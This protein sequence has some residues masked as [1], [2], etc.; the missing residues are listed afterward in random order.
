[1]NFVVTWA[2]NMFMKAM[3]KCVNCVHCENNFLSYSGETETKLKEKTNTSGFFLLFILSTLFSVCFTASE[4]KESLDGK[5]DTN[6]KLFL[7]YFTAFGLIV[8]LFLL[9]SF[10]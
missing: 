4:S 3:T 8:Y 6:F 7:C 9:I 10:L 2:K 1:M 5:I